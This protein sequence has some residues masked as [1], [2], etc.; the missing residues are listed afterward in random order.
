MV[1]VGNDRANFTDQLRKF[2]LFFSRL[3]ISKQVY[4]CICMCTAYMFIFFLHLDFYLVRC[5]GKKKKLKTNIN[6]S[7]K[8]C[9][10][11]NEGKT[12]SKSEKR[13]MKLLVGNGDIDFNVCAWLKLGYD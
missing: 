1:I 10:R 6:K 4:A 12:N 13:Q 11:K 8:M 3:C 5:S 2:L 9:A 7:C